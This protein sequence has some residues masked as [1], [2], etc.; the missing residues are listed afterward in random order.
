MNALL[1]S[2]I[3]LSLAGTPDAPPREQTDEGLTFRPSNPATCKQRADSVYELMLDRVPLDKIAQILADVS[4]KSI[5]VSPG[6]QVSITINADGKS[7]E[8]RSS[9]Q[10]FE[11]ISAELEKQGVHVID[12]DVVKFVRPQRPAKERP[13]K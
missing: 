4:C 3:A 13:K 11:A 8:T 7:S 2:L 1:A 10:L 12:G 9:R 5:V 6:L